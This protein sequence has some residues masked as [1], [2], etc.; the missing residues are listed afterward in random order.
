MWTSRR[1]RL[2]DY[3]NA[4]H[5]KALN[6]RYYCSREVL[7]WTRTGMLSCEKKKKKNLCESHSL[8]FLNIF[9]LNTGL[10]VCKQREIIVRLCHGA[11][12]PHKWDQTV[13]NMTAEQCPLRVWMLD[14]FLLVSLQDYRRAVTSHGVTFWREAPEELA[15]FP[16]SCIY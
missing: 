10:L 5:T 14:L 15:Q 3:E 11:A 6:S 1:G 4:A 16:P 12:Y 8:I 7:F 13:M 9:D 2:K